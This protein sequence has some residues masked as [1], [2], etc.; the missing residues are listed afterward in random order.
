MRPTTLVPFFA[1]LA[2][3]TPTGSGVPTSAQDPGDPVEV[4]DPVEEPG[5]TE[6]D[7]VAAELV[8]I[9]RD[10]VLQD[11]LRIGT[12]HRDQGASVN[13]SNGHGAACPA[14]DDR[15]DRYLVHFAQ[16]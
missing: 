15:S 2:A 1:F 12:G 13:G 7:L 9:G 14:R 16:M 4:T 11:M 6:A 10:Q 3:C 8:D 5:V